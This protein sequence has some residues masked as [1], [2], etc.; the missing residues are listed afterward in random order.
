MDS[1]CNHTFRLSCEA[2][3]GRHLLSMIGDTATFVSASESSTSVAPLLAPYSQFSQKLQ[4]T[5]TIRPSGLLGYPYCAVIE[6]L[7]PGS[8]LTHVTLIG[9]TTT[10]TL[11]P[12]DRIISLDNEPVNRTGSNLEYH[13][14]PTSIEFLQPGSNVVQHGTIY[15]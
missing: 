7:R 9:G 4:V 15:I 14:G 11:Q 8:P 6:D 1:R 3:E 5:Y 2:L 13:I 12:G 10:L